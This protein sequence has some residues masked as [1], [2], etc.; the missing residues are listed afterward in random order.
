[1]IRHCPF[2]TGEQVMLGTD[3]ILIPIMRRKES[4]DDPLKTMA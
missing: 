1:M 4:V 3:Y 2:S